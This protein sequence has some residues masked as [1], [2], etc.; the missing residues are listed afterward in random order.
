VGDGIEFL[1]RFAGK[2]DLLYLDFWVP[3]PEG[4]VPGTGRAEAYRRT[5]HAARDKMSAR[6]MILIDD[7]DH[8]PPW[9]HTLMI[10]DA[11][12]DGF[13]VLYT[14]RQTLLKR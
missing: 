12:H 1:E 10:P 4:A 7:T 6:S 5:Y 3:D 8:V 11:R 9:K 14:G 2:I 13:V